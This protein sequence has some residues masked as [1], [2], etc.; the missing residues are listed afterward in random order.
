VWRIAQIT[1]ESPLLRSRDLE[2]IKLDE[3]YNYFQS[4]WLLS[5]PLDPRGP[6]SIP[7][8]Y[9]PIATA[10]DLCEYDYT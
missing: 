6:F 7:D 1:N 3:K 5:Q 4:A 8:V 2:E 10:E 9:P